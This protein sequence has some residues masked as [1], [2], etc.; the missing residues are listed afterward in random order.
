MELFFQIAVLIALFFIAFEVYGLKAEIS[1]NR[2]FFRSS[3]DKKDSPTIN[4]NVGT[5]PVQAAKEESPHE[6][7]PAPV[8]P[9]APEPPPPASPAPEAAAEE[10]L[11][12]LSEPAPEEPK[13]VPSLLHKAISANATTS[14]LV[15]LKCPVCQAENSTYRSECFNCGAKLR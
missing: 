9:A 11:E 7:E 8:E 1:R 13:P 2:N 12:P 5:L 14:G 10:I 15:A 4:V 6:G 3:E